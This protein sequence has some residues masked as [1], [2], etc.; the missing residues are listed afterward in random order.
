MSWG[1]STYMALDSKT[2]KFYWTWDIDTPGQ[3]LEYVTTVYTSKPTIAELVIVYSTLSRLFEECV[4]EETTA[5]GREMLKSQAR[6]CE[7]NLAMIISRLPFNLPTTFDYILALY[8]IVRSHGY[9][10]SQYVMVLSS[11]SD[12]LYGIPLQTA[13]SLEIHRS[14]CPDVPN[15]WLLS[16]ASIGSRNCAANTPTVALGLDDHH[17]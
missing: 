17:H 13:R 9:L 6:Q 1:R 3:I 5:S 7:E 4:R 12:N 14:C 11:S 10:G 2:L 8:Y 16:R 15:T